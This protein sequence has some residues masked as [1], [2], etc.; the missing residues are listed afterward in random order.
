WKQGELEAGGV[1]SRGS[2][3]QGELEA[4]GVGSRGSWKQ[5]DGSF[6]SFLF[7]KQKNRPPAS[8][9]PCFPQK[10]RFDVPPKSPP[11]YYAWLLIGA[12]YGQEVFI[13]K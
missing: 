10:T 8:P 9:S 1:G 2:W 4:G 3:K 11:G 12:Y 6:A 5:G 13:W 7:R